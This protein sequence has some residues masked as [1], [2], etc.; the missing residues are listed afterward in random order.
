[1]QCR[2]FNQVPRELNQWKN[3]LSYEIGGL[4][5]YVGHLPSL[6]D[7]TPNVAAIQALINYWDPDASVFRFGM[8]ELT[9]TLEELEG[10]LQ[11]PGKGSP[12]IY[13]SGGTKEQFCRFLGLRNNSLDQHPDARSCPLRF[14]YD[15]FGEKESF[16]CHQIDFFITRRQWEEKRVQAFDLVLINLLL[17]PQ[18]HGKVTFATIN[19][20]QSLFL[21]IRGTTPTLIPVVIADIFSALINC[22]KKGGFF[23]ASNLILQMWIIEHLVKRSLNPLDPCLPVEN[24]IDSHRERVSRYYRVMSSSQFIEE[25][26]SLTPEKV[27]WVLDWTKIRDPAFR[28]TQHDFIPLAGVNG[29]VAYIP[30]RVMRQF[31]YPQSIPMVQGVEDFRLS[32][33][34]ES[35]SMVLEAW[36]NLQGLENLQLELVNKVAPAVMPGYNEWIKQR[37]EHDRARQQSASASPEEQMKRLRKELEESQAQLIMA[38]KVLEDTQVQLRREKKKNERLEEAIDALDR[39]REGARK[40]SLR[41]SRE[42]QSTSLLRH[43]DFVNMVTK[44]IDEIVKKD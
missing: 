29:L 6:V 2:M 27:Q 43:R 30:Q 7:I 25:F 40:L 20:I 13:P 17:F 31:G 33:V 21:G 12:M 14:L 42:S 10:L 24:W 18:R 11:V 41:S 38:N 22:Q 44:T 8:C 16:E 26:N 28:T 39:I 32:T 4:F 1:M 37:V 23:Y 3:N 34:T 35:R 5:Q 36:G 9:P 19:M 15:R